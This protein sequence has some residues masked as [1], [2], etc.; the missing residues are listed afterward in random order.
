MQLKFQ[1][2][3]PAVSLKLGKT[4]GYVT[5]QPDF[6]AK[7]HFSNLSETPFTNNKTR[8]KEKEMA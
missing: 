4:T 3:Q 2:V 7:I 8:G 1:Q 6:Q 5:N